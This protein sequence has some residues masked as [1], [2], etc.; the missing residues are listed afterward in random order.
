MFRLML[1]SF[2]F[3]LVSC[4]SSSGTDK[5]IAVDDRYDF[6]NSGLLTVA[7]ADGVLKND[8]GE[9]LIVT[10]LSGPSFSEGFVFNNDGSFSYTAHLETDKA[11]TDQFEYQIT[12]K[13][14][15]TQ[16]ALATITVYPRPK[17]VADEYRVYVGQANDVTVEKGVLANDQ[18]SRNDSRAEIRRAPTQA[19][20]FVLNSDGSFSYIPKATASG[21]DSFSYIV[22][23]DLQSTEEQE[24]ELVIDTGV[25]SGV[26]DSFQIESGKILHLEPLQGWLRND[27]GLDDV[28]VVVQ[29]RPLHAI[30]FNVSATGLLTYRTVS[31][32]V[33]QDSFSYT[34]HKNKKIIGPFSVDIDITQP[35]DVSVTPW[36]YDQCKEYQA[37]KNVDG[38]LSG[39]GVVGASFELV[40]EPR[41]G[42]LTSFDGASGQFSYTRSTTNRG[43]DAFSYR[44]FDANGNYV[45]DASQELI[46]VPYR[47][48]PIGDSITSG[49]ELYDSEINADRPPSGIR[50]GYRKFLKDELT[51]MGYSIDLVGSRSEGYNVAGFTD[52]QHNGFPGVSDDFV[53]TNIEQWLDT[54]GTD[55]IL[56]HIGTNATKSHI[57]H[58]RSIG[59]TIENWVEREDNPITLMMAKL[60]ARTDTTGGG[61]AIRRFNGL[62]EGYVEE[63]I[64]AGDRI[65][66]VDQYNALEGGGYMSA[67]KLHPRAEG[68]QLM[69][70]EWIKR[71]QETQAIAKCF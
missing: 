67:D 27:S 49:V 34:L 4:S 69:S 65:H 53:S 46:A 62:I 11:F 6:A 23:D 20:T 9:E 45:A 68:Y 56:M 25:F 28:I 12:G 43:Q 13:D 57:D 36:L 15:I 21:V 58:I 10:L 42:T 63:R 7:I 33:E 54:T 52:S 48:M 47:I 51:S 32:S 50:V 41:F 24:V 26:N 1:L 18:L 3:L 30:D 38:V 70:R 37:G 19:D 44:L 59:T 29:K 17:T 22:R 8:Q 5:T 61:N 39:A 60:I 35:T 14:E 31:E 16:N 64:L 40:S 66:I 2:V 55:L 71:L